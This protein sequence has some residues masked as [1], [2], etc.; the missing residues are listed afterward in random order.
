MHADF[1]A[2]NLRYRD[3]DGKIDIKREFMTVPLTI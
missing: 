2:E 1:F 3:P